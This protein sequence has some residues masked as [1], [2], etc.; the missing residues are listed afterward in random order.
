MKYMLQIYGN[1]TR[2]QVAAMSDEERT[3]LF[4]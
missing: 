2:D 4:T 1:L 3:A